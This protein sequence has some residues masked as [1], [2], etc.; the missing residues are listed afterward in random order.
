MIHK[1]KKVYV[2]LLTG[3]LFF[4]MFR[5]SIT[6]GSSMENTLKNNS[7]SLTTRLIGKLDYKDIVIINTSNRKEIG[8]DMII[9]RV[10]G[11]PGD[12]LEFRDNQL[13]RNGELIIEDYIKEPM[14]ST[15]NFSLEL[16]ENEY[17]C[18][19]DNRNN[20]L[21]SRVEYIG[22]F[23]REEIMYKLIK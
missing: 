10:I 20:S 23:R 15:A 1:Y 22:P 7:I 16:K 8:Q 21:D 2:I 9:K 11:L 19:G 13:Y 6:S 18:C 3:L 4:S 14:N 5:L 17:F 12:V